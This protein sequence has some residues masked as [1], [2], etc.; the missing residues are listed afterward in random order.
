MNH[1]RP[2]MAGILASY[3]ANPTLRINL[4]AG[5]L[6]NYMENSVYPMKL[7]AE[8]LVSWNGRKFLERM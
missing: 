2:F 5:I 1:R 8:D 4:M 3:T 7:K 6:A